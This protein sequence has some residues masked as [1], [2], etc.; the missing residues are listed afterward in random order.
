[1]VIVG[2][3]F[4]SL[5]Y[6]LVRY[7]LIF[8]PLNC[9]AYLSNMDILFVGSTSR[10]TEYKKYNIPDGKYLLKG[11]TKAQCQDLCQKDT[12]CAAVDYNKYNSSIYR[13]YIG[14]FFTFSLLQMHLIQF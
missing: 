11:I 8:Y 2:Y 9:H 10:W 6:N 5:F 14:H 7:L 1:M 3:Q 13:R 12:R 4:V